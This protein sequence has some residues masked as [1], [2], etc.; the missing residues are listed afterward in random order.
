MRK[1]FLEYYKLILSKVSF[2]KQ[3]LR[4]EYRKAMHVL[5]EYETEQLIEW[6]NEKGLLA[7]CSTTDK[8]PKAGPFHFR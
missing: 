1:S 5:S 7:K 3:L 2:D 4:K 6:M 8:W